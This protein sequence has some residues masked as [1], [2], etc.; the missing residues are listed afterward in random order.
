LVDQEIIE[1][2]VKY[3]GI[4]ENKIKISEL[5]TKGWEIV[6]DSHTTTVFH[7]IP[8]NHFKKIILKK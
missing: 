6:Y 4:Y 1:D 3:K 7:L 5:S 8:P 2:D